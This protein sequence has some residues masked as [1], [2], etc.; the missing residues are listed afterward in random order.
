MGKATAGEYWVR[1]KKKRTDNVRRSTYKF[2]WRWPPIAPFSSLFGQSSAWGSLVSQRCA[3]RARKTPALCCRLHQN[4]RR[5]T[6][7]MTSTTNTKFSENLKVPSWVDPTQKTQ[8]KWA[9]TKFGLTQTKKTENNWDSYKKITILTKKIFKK[10][11]K[12]TKKTENKQPKKKFGS[13]ICH[14]DMREI[15]SS[16]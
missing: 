7:M 2:L 9:D 12:K 8:W 11:A 5:R 16:C 3:P 6:C 13:I 4:A 1:E 15:L 14:C 10:I